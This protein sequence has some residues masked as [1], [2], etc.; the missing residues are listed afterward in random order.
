MKMNCTKGLL[1]AATLM[2]AGS[3]A[4]E[5]RAGYDADGSMATGSMSMNNSSMMRQRNA[6]MLIRTLSEEL[7]EINTLAA[8]QA[9][10]RAMGD[11]ES[12]RIARLWGV[13]IRE[14][15]AAGPTLRNLIRANGG[16]PD[17]AMILKAPVLGS[18]AQMLE[19]THRDHEAA[20]MTSQMRYG[21][22]N[23]RAIKRAMNKRANL[24][25]K[26]IR[27]M[28]PFHHHDHNMDMG[29]TTTTRRTT[30]TT[31][32]D[33]MDD[34]T[35][36]DTTVDTTAVDTVPMDTTQTTTTTTTTQ[37]T[38]VEDPAIDATI[39]ADATT[40]GTVTTETTVIEGDADMD[41]NVE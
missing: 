15:K 28:M 22:T 34:T 1:V 19:A 3:A 18:K 25:R 6:Q 31:S 11:S 41:A 39:D 30:T 26:H 32:M 14:H 17:Q 36:T 12:Q 8:Q 23:S 13:W 40:D 29:T 37:T 9:R 4:H 38:I 16:N 35:M 2:F 24:A 27:Q 5:A 20:V 33:D 7:T 21:M 10:F